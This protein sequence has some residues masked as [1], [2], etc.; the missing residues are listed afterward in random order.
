M[1]AAAAP[2]WCGWQRPAPAGSWDEP[3]ALLSRAIDCS[4][5]DYRTD[6]LRTTCEQSG[7]LL[8]FAASA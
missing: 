1:S 5:T 7:F 8:G 4:I 6:T 3:Y 2:S